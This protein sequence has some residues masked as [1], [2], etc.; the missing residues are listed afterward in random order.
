M[1][2]LQPQPYAVPSFFSEKKMAAARKATIPQ[3]TTARKV[4]TKTT[5]KKPAPKVTVKMTGKTGVKATLK[6][7]AKPV[8]KAPVKSAA[9]K[10]AKPMPKKAAAMKKVPVKQPANMSGPGEGDKAPAFMLPSLE[11]NVSLASFKGK[12]VV[13][14]FYPK[15]DTSGCTKEACDFQ[16]GMPRF[17]KGDTVILGISKDNVASHKKF[18]KKYGLKFNLA[19]DENTETATAYGVWQE[20][21]MYGRKYMGMDRATFLIDAKGVIRKVWRNVKVPG[22]VAEVMAA[23]SKI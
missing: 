20:K 13:L 21:S 4:A 11:G 14:Y 10:S 2:R 9:K 19:S 17:K 5:S 6:T 7:A 3:A 18:A 16:D 22:H 1:M 15:D 8:A 12:N 23:A